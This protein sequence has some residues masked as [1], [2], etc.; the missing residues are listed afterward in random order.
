VRILVGSDLSSASDEALR[1]A[2]TLARAEGAELAVCHVLPEPQFRDLFPKE[3]ERDVETLAT[4][5]PRTSAALHAQVEQLQGGAA[6][7]FN[8]FVERGSAYAELVDCAERWA[9]DLIVIGNHGRAE[10]KHLFLGGVAEK[11]ARYA[12]CSALVARK[13]REGAVLVATDLSDPAQLAIAAG[14]RSQSPKAPAGSDAC[15]RQLVASRCAGN[16]TAGS[17]SSH[18]LR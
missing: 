7:A 12:P 8:V 11:V 16:G 6:L 15:K 18:G 14:V 13:G 9:A 3:H 2:I 17:Q 1:Q 10:L 5:E 4:L